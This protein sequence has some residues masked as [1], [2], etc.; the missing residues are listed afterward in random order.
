MYPFRRSFIPV[1][2]KSLVDSQPFD[3]FR[4]LPLS[5]N[6]DFFQSN[7]KKQKKTSAS[8]KKAADEE[9]QRKKFLCFT[10]LKIIAF[11]RFS[12]PYTFYY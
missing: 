1:K 6:P 9:K 10:I 2:L 8:A 5:L 7:F 3:F 12:L 11:N 4:M